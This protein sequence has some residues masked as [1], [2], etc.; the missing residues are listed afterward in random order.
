MYNAGRIGHKFLPIKLT[1]EN[2]FFSAEAIF[3]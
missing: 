2:L 3:K 1:L